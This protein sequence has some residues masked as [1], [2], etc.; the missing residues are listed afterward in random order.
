MNARK[1][2]ASA[3][4]CHLERHLQRR[5]VASA[6]IALFSVEIQFEVVGMSQGVERG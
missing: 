6:S 3:C 4:D 5:E 2:E 1:V